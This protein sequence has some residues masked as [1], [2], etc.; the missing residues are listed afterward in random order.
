MEYASA[1]A[2][3]HSTSAVQLQRCNPVVGDAVGRAVT[4]HH[5][6]SRIQFG[7]AA[8]RTAGPDGAVLGRDHAPHLISVHTVALGPGAPLRLAICANMQAIYTQIGSGPKIAGFVSPDCP[9]R[10]TAQTFRG[11]PTL[12]FLTTYPAPH[13]PTP[14]SDPTPAF[15]V[16]QDPAGRL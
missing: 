6:C 8:R 9:D 5:A 16:H 11:G 15:P 13:H 4:C 1:R 7:Y 3:P 14:E 12:P 10:V 2:H